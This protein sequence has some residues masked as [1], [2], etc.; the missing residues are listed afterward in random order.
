MTNPYDTP[1]ASK[2]PAA[3]SGM[4]FRLWLMMFLEFFI[5]G[6]WLPLVFGYLNHLGFSESQQTWILIA[7]PVSA[8][9][10]MFFSNQFA[11][12]NFDA[13]RFC[14]F[15]HL[16]GGLAMLGL[17]FV[18]DYTLFLLLMWLHCLLYVPTISITNSIAFN[19]MKDAKREFGLVRMGG[20]IGWIAASWPLLFILSDDPADAKYT[21]LIAGIASLVMAGYS[22]TLPHTP[23]NREAKGLAWLKALSTLAIPFI[24]V[25]WIVTMVDACVHD[26]YFMWTGGFLESIGIEQRW[27]M[28]IMSIGQIAEIGTM[29]VLGFFLTR[30]GWKT[31]MIIGILGHAIRF[32]IF[33]Y[34]PI[35]A[36]VIAANVLHGICY[37]FFFATV[38]IFV[39]EYLPKDIRSS[40]QGLFNLMILGGGPIVA[41]I[42][43]PRLFGYFTDDSGG[44]TTV[45][46]QGLFTIPCIMAVVAAALLAVFFWPPKLKPGEDATSSGDG[47]TDKAVAEP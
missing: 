36:V 44:V 39:D 24:L 16:A 33:A 2:K 32:G 22:L 4:V 29:A 27:I 9:V 11:D 6:A 30:L 14:A 13:E 38:Y 40:T 37:A 46:Y 45:D 18:T 26:L 41:R 47:L 19:A 17:F 7:F 34:V 23:P 31:T 10:A 35:P 43:A 1:V 28:P 5:W 21:Y 15:S 25:L 42:L 3:S 8:I 12:R 20:T